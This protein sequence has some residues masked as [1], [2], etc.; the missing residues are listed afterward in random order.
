MKPEDLKEARFMFG[1][2]A[3]SFAREVG[4]GDARTVRRWESG[5]SR[6]PGSIRRL[7]EIWTD[8]RCH[9]DLKPQSNR[10]YVAE[11]EL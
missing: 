11:K 9:P 6:I 1:M 8:P 5:E 7:V 2:S 3:E 4:I 10:I